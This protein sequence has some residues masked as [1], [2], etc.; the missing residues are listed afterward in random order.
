MTALPGMRGVRAV[1]WRK[2]GKRVMAIGRQPQWICYNSASKVS[3]CRRRGKTRFVG[4]FDDPCPLGLTQRVRRSRAIRVRSTIIARQTVDLPALQRAGG[5]AGQSTGRGKPR[6]PRHRL[7]RCHTSGSGGLPDGSFVRVL[8]EARRPF[9]Q[10]PCPLVLSKKLSAVSGPVGLP[11]H[12]PHAVRRDPRSRPAATLP[13]LCRIQTLLAAP[14]APRRLIHPSCG[15]QRL[16]SR[17]SRPALAASSPVARS[18]G[19]RSSVAAL[20]PTSR[21]TCSTDELSGGNSRTT[22]RSLYACPYRATS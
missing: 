19:Q 3:S 2:N 16:Q 18:R 7:E 6:S 8:V 21:D 17:R 13:Q 14:A 20:T 10:A 9:R 15:D 22:I 12:S 11:R 1:W 4:H 5:D